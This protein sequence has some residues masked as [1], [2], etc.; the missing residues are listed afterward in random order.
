[1][2]F[3]LKKKEVIEINFYERSSDT[4]M[5]K[6]VW[7]PQRS[8]A[9]H[10]QW[11]LNFAFLISSI[12]LSNLIQAHRRKR[13]WAPSFLEVLRDLSAYIFTGQNSELEKAGE[14]LALK[15]PMFSSKSKF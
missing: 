2:K 8:S 11:S 1:M 4:E 13:R 14:V 15:H 6:L 7:W 9:F 5:S 10:H 3:W 12:I